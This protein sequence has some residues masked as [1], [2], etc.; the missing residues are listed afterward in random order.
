MALLIGGTLA[1][2]QMPVK[3]SIFVTIEAL[4]KLAYFIICEKGL[5]HYEYVRNERKN[6]SRS[7]STLH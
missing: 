4:Y 6:P 5:A 3:L 2:Y 1:T 7:L